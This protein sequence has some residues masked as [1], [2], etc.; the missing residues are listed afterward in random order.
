MIIRFDSVLT[1]CTVI[2][3]VPG[4]NKNGRVT[5]EVPPRWKVNSH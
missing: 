3:H 4:G 5:V 1:I 2:T